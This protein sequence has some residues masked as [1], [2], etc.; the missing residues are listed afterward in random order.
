M[1]LWIDPD[2]LTVEQAVKR[3]G[4]GD[5]SRLPRL[6]HAFDALAAPHALRRDQLPLS[7][8]RRHHDLSKLLGGA[9]LNVP[10]VG[11]TAQFVVTAT[12]RRI[13][14]HI[15]IWPRNALRGAIECQG[16]NSLIL[17]APSPAQGLAAPRLRVDWLN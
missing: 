7:R 8:W 6:P 16:D 9:R 1:S 2:T 10:T 13:H 11:N 5:K 3:K 17:Q 14:I 12:H 4:E 15:D